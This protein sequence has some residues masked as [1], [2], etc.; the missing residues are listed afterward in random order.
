MNKKLIIIVAII[1]ILIVSLGIY[2]LTSSASKPV[3]APAMMNLNNS[4]SKQVSSPA[5]DRNVKNL[6]N[7]WAYKCS[8]NDVGKGSGAVYRYS[9]DNTLN[10]YPS[11]AIAKSW[12]ANWGKASS[13]DCGGLTEGMP[14][15]LKV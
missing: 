11:P 8:A 9:G 5:Q 13:I 14:M 7:G 2:F 12:D 6:N 15:T 3:S 1:V 4:E 10:H